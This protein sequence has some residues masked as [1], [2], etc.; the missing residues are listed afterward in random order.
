MS[1]DTFT[2]G[3]PEPPPSES[4]PG[5][6]VSSDT[7]IIIVAV[8]S[9]FV[10]LWLCGCGAF[11]YLKRLTTKGKNRDIEMTIPQDKGE[12]AIPSPSTTVVQAFAV[13]MT[14]TQQQASPRQSAATATVVQALPLKTAT[15][16]NGPAEVGIA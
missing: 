8:I 9:G 16:E 2:D 4:P 14:M 5:L 1:S 12:Q 6:S 10:A 13:E 7:I 11:M 3:P 15:M